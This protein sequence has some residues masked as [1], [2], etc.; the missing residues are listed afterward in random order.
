MNTRS[1][2]EGE[3]GDLSSTA[4]P[5]TLEVQFN[6]HK[7][8]ERSVLAFSVNWVVDDNFVSPKSS[9][10]RRVSIAVNRVVIVV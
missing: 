8:R 2:Y 10:G 9:P 5:A 3:P 4:V 6:N 7:R 1:F